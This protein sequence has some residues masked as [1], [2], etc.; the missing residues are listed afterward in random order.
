M[1]YTKQLLSGSTNGRGIKVVATATLGTTI[2]TAHATAKDEVYLYAYNSDTADVDL[3][4][5]LGGVTAPDDNIVI[6][7]PVKAGRLC[8]VDGQPLTGGVVVT[9]FASS[10]NKVVITGYVNRIT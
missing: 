1:A 8:I 2:H 5:E 4:I 10:A 3:T 9:A 7:L 6:T